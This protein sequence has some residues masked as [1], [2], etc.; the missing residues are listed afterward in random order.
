MKNPLPALLFLFC[1]GCATLPGALDPGSTLISLGSLGQTAFQV[2][3]IT[4]DSGTMAVAY[5]P[6]Q[7]AADTERMLRETWE[8]NYQLAKTVR[9]EAEDLSWQ[10]VAAATARKSRAEK[11]SLAL[12]AKR[13]VRTETVREEI[14]VYVT[15]SGKTLR[16]PAE[17]PGES[18]YPQVR[19]RKAAVPVHAYTAYYF[20]RSGQPSGILAEEGPW[21]GPCRTPYGYGT[22]VRAVGK[23]TPAETAQLRAGDIITTV[24]GARAEYAAMF[25]LLRPGENILSV[26]RNGQYATM[27]LYMPAP[28]RKSPAAP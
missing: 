24:N 1:A 26:C 3:R 5:L 10:E 7:Y 16:D 11:A 17:S 9:W 2:M 25:A 14:T 23:G 8:Q 12:V 18:F 22:H 28:A 21:D 20:V 6:Q 13:P 4:T 15:P 19:A 27:R